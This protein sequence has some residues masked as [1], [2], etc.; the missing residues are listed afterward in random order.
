MKYYYKIEN[1]NLIE[2]CPIMYGK[3]QGRHI[4]FPKIGSG[5]CTSGCKHN[6]SYNDNEKYIICKELTKLRREQKLKRIL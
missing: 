3:R 1:N 6:I 2:E 4:H 5:F